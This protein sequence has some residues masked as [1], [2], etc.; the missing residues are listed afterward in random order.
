MH[1]HVSHLDFNGVPSTRAWKQHQCYFSVPLNGVFLIEREAAIE[2]WKMSLVLIIS[3]LKAMALVVVRK[4]SGIPPFKGLNL[5]S[6][7]PS[8]KYRL[9][10]IIEI[11]FPHFPFHFSIYLP[12]FISLLPSYLPNLSFSIDHHLALGYISRQLSLYSKISC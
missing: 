3:A 8:I 6:L 7:L 2:N 11:V 12:D 1:V 5:H 9:V 10:N 4:Y